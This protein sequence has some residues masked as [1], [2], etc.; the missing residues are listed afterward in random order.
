MPTKIFPAV[1]T[2]VTK[3]FCDWTES[4]ESL[5]YG[6]LFYQGGFNREVVFDGN[7]FKKLHELVW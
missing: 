2:P 1:D 5:F 7:E 6:A 3:E 4:Y